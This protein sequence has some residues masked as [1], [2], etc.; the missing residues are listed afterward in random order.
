MKITGYKHELLDKYMSEITS[1]VAAESGIPSDRYHFGKL[2]LQSLKDD[3]DFLMQ[4]DGGTGESETNGSVLKRS[5]RCV[6]CF[7]KLG[8]KIGDVIIL[9]GAN[10]L[11]QAIPFYA[12]LFE[13]IIIAAIDK[14]L[15]VSELNDVFSAN[16]PKLIFCQGD[17]VQDAKKA[18]ELAGGDGRVISYDRSPDTISFSDMMEIYGEDIDVKDYKAAD[19]DPE[20]TIAL[21]VAT[22][23]STGLPK[24]A[25]LTH[26]NITV[27]STYFGSFGKKFPRITKCS[28][29]VSPLQWLSALIHYLVGPIFQYSRLQTSAELTTEHI[30]DMINKYRPTLLIS[31]PPT[32]ITLLKEAETKECDFSCFEIVFLAGSAVSDHLKAT[33]QS[34]APNTQVV[35]GYGMSEIGGIVFFPYDV[36]LSSCGKPFAHMQYKLMNVETGE[37][38]KEPHKIGELWVKA[39]GG[40][41]GY[42]NYPLE[43]AEAI[44]KDGW[45][46]SGD[47]HYRDEDGNYYFV[48]RLK[49]LLKYRNHQI[50]PVELEEVIQKLPGVLHVAVSGVPDPDC[51][52][53]PIAFVVPRPEA[54]ITEKDV[55]NIVKE[56]L[57]DTK[58]L[59]GG[60]VML[61]E[62]PLLPSTKLDRTKLK[63]W[64]AAFAKKN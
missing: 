14:T 36:P 29:I 42:Y 5:I 4:T 59:R 26:K 52:E 23:G 30:F 44:T 17:K 62:L 7:K 11:D 37:E 49:L 33:L 63:Q 43:T 18:L 25:I 27:S 41:R 12:A 40:V 24:A 47:L 64:A 8:L 28:L 2:V 6:A 45:Y 54:D 58:L 22:S 15:G 20:E 19:F 31:S 55:K 48:E 60:V 38:V 61:K 21:V 32:M 13:G 34:R 46:K 3:P 10:N 57:T 56:N 9:M 1:R 16:K 39:P 53:L 50:S 51:G 35:N